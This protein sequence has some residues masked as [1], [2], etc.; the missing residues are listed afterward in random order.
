MNLRE[1]LSFLHLPPLWLVVVTLLAIA[2][3]SIPAWTNAAWG[4]DLGIY[5]GITSSMI[6]TQHLF[7]EYNGWGSSYQFFPVLYLIAAFLHI[8]TGLDLL[9]LLPKIAPVIGGLTIPIFYLIVLELLRDKKV[10]LASSAL[11]AIAPFHVYQTS[12]AA[13]L[14]A[15]HFFMLLSIYFFIRH[16][17][18]RRFVLPLILSTTLLIFSHHLTTYFYIISITAMF[19]V[20]I[21]YREKI[22][23]KVILT[24]TYIFLTSTLAFA[25]WA[26]IAKP[27]FYNFM[28]GGIHLPP[29]Y[30]VLLYYL[31]LFGG[32]FAIWIRKKHFKS[33]LENKKSILSFKL[34]LSIAFFILLGVESIFVFLLNVP[35]INAKIPIN[36]FLYSIPIILLLSLSVAGF[37]FL[38]RTEG[39]RL[40]AGWSFA[41]LTS[42]LYAMLFDTVLYPDRHLEYLIVPL[43]VPA[44]LA[45]IE[46]LREIEAS[47]HLPHRT[48]RHRRV[49][50]IAFP[51]LAVVLI[52]SNAAVIYPAVETSNIADERISEPCINAIRWMKGN[53]SVGSVVASDH[54]LSM[55]IW[56]AGFNI[57]M[58]K[59]N[60][61]W[62]AEN[63]SGCYEEF[64]ELN[65]SYILID[66]I[67]RNEVVNVG[68]GESYYMDNESYEKFSKEPFE[69]IYR[70]ATLN[71]MGEEIHWAEVYAVNMSY[72]DQHISN[73][74]K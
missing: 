1:K 29:Q 32:F 49:A 26:L 64:K 43:C 71:N 11:L 42:L 15:G 22:D 54:R 30:T 56:A 67:M 4:N 65:V 28:R 33:I 19:F 62:T 74:E 59:T 37:P 6:K 70:N 52:L 61:T 25:Y 48:E 40:I 18:N 3:R 66:D 24:L 69:L 21:L 45:I 27:V 7:V 31:I 13:P 34:R 10:A 50:K 23:R 51:A 38:K 8:V 39:G 72:I 20:D 63:W 73:Q 17:K 41:I 58:G 57:T 36:A 12:H 2:L 60:L 53:I 47:F 5:Y 44:A 55:L 14:T 16:L 35:K 9:W 46:S 68:V